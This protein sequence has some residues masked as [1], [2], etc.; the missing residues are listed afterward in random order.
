MTE[1][2]DKLWTCKYV[3]EQ[4]WYS[5]PLHFLFSAL[6]FKA[7][8]FPPTTFF[9]N[10]VPQ[11]GQWFNSSLDT[12]SLKLD[13]FQVDH[14]LYHINSLAYIMGDVAGVYHIECFSSTFQLFL[15]HFEIPLT[16]SNTEF[17]VRTLFITKESTTTS[18]LPSRTHMQTAILYKYMYNCIK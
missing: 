18:P 13:C 16:S 6:S 11:V 1:D 17:R 10:L 9:P 5:P 3:C 7:T 14:P 4:H 12:T 15:E 2:L 8:S